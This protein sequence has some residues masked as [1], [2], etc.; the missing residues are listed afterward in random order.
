MGQQKG[1]KH[2]EETK[3]KISE[4][5]KGRHISPQT[6]FKKGSIISWKSSGKGHPMLGRHHSEETKKKMRE[7]HIGMKGKHMSEEAKLKMSI[8]HKGK[9]L[10]DEHLV[11]L[12]K[13][14]NNLNKNKI[15]INHPMYGKHHTKETLE[16]LENNRYSKIRNKTLE[17]IYGIEKANIIKQK[18]K[19]AMKMK[20]N[21]GELNSLLKP[22]EKHPNWQGG[23]SFEPYGVAFNNQLKSYIRW[24]DN[25]TCQQCNIPEKELGYKL[26]VHHIDFNKKNNTIQNLISLCKTCHSQTNFN[27][28]DWINYFQTKLNFIGGKNR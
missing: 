4:L 13:H 11:N 5:L 17:E 15:G 3:Q 24:M 22:K 12:L 21:S 6:E 27:R 28:Q 18:M 7:N 1:F 25:H 26:G 23:I 8:A 9:K 20:V 14:L 16:K 2:T 19:Y 10:S